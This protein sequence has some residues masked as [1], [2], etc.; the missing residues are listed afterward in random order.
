MRKS[1]D[2]VGYRCSIQLNHFWCMLRY[3]TNFVRKLPWVL[4][5]T[6]YEAQRGHVESSVNGRSPGSPMEACLAIMESGSLRIDLAMFAFD[7]YLD[8]NVT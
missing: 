4:P 7:K 5:Q 3:L 8:N 6:H 2:K 1:D